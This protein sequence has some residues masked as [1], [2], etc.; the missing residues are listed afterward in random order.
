VGSNTQYPSSY[1]ADTTGAGPYTVVASDLTQRLWVRNNHYGWAPRA[2]LRHDKGELT[3][4]GEWREHTGRHWGE[5]TWS[6]ALAP[7]VQ[8]NFV[9]YDYTGRSERPLR[10]R[11]RGVR[12]PAGPPSHGKPSAP[13]HPLRDRKDRLQRYDFDLHYTS[14]NPRWA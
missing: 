9:F 6:A 11:S 14:L 12:P 1:Y 3:V 4:G 7:G 8:P 2:R 13:T 10:I 5:I